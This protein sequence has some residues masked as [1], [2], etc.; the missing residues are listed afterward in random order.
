MT[1]KLCSRNLRRNRRCNNDDEQKSTRKD[2][3]RLCGKQGCKYHFPKIRC[4]P[5]DRV[6]FG[7]KDADGWA[8]ASIQSYGIEAVEGI[9]SFT[10]GYHTVGNQRRNEL[11]YLLG[12]RAHD[13]I[14]LNQGK[15][16]AIVFSARLDGTTVSMLMEGAMNGVKFKDYLENHLVPDLHKDDVVA[17]DNLPCH[18]IAG[19]REAIEGADAHPAYLPPY[20]PALNPI[21]EM[22]SKIKAHLRKV[23]PPPVK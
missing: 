14:P 12:R 15:I 17:L 4:E 21:E 9:D 1:N 23:E 20:S 3:G 22:W 5:E 18:K 10:A 2:G 7:C 19:I 6:P 11:G 13:A 8:E 16:T